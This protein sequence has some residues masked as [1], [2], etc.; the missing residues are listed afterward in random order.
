MKKLLFVCSLLLA[1]LASADTAFQTYYP[2]GYAWASKP[3][4]SAAITGMQIRVTDVGTTEIFTVCDGTNWV[5]PS[6][7]NLCS[8]N[9]Q[10]ADS[11]S[12]AGDTDED[13]YAT[14]TI[15]GGLMGSNSSLR[16]NSMFAFTNSGNNK[17]LRGRWSTVSGTAFISTIVT[18]QQTFRNQAIIG[19]RNATNSQVG[20]ATGTSAYGSGAGAVVTAAIDTSADTTFVLTCQKATG[21]ETCTLESYTVELMP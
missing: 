20:L 18:T 15:P 21:T 13:T 19:N 17:T 3:T 9:A 6:V 8:S 10:V 16:V 7:I 11:D 12:G 14:C 2:P 4:C 1:S 5:L